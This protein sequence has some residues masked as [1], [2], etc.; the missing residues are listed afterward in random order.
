MLRLRFPS[1]LEIS[2]YLNRVLALLEKKEGR[3]EVVRP[4]LGKKENRLEAVCLLLE[5]KES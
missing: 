3:L 1:Y 4:L 2:Y 5:E